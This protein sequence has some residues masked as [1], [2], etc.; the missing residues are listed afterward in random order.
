MTMTR[1]T[2]DRAQRRLLEALAELNKTNG[3]LAGLLLGMPLAIEMAEETDQPE[4]ANVWRRLAD[5]AAAALHDLKGAS[6]G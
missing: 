4:L 1:S 6:N 3:G 5:L 2:T